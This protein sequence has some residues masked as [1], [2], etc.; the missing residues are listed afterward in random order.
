MNPHYYNVNVSWN[1]DRLGIMCSPELNTQGD[2]CIEVA[3]P[4]E[5]PKGIPGIWSPE[6][7][8]TAAVSSCLMT[9]FL[10]IAENSGLEFID[11]QCG[12]KGKLEKVD[13]VLMM[14]EILLEPVLT[15]RDAKDMDRARRILEK[16][17]AACLI[18]NSVKAK[19]IMEPKVIVGE[20]SL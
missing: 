16:S 7:L 6:H 17:E 12:S 5:F 18:S 11:F 14:S 3:T 9:T 19:V 1:H 8:F 20:K 4:P 2:A 13:G 15:I 10:A